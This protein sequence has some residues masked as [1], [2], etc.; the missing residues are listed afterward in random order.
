MIWHCS[1]YIILVFKSSLT[2]YGHTGG[3]LILFPAMELFI[4]PLW[5][6]IYCH[7][8][9]REPCMFA[10]WYFVALQAFSFS[11]RA[12]L[13]GQKNVRTVPLTYLKQLY[14]QVKIQNHCT[15]NKLGHGKNRWPMELLPKSIL[16]FHNSPIYKRQ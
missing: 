2:Y 14:F 13:K 7:S 9:A 3:P 6:V 1:L 11:L 4:V 5:D 12:S 16:I 10:F 8:V 15:R